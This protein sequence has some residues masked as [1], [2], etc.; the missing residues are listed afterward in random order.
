VCCGAC[1]SVG[2]CC[3]DRDVGECGMFC[4]MLFATTALVA[5]P[6]LSLIF[7]VLRVEDVHTFAWKEV[8]APMWAF[9]IVAEIAMCVGAGFV[10]W[11]KLLRPWMER[12]ESRQD[13]FAP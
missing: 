11:E 7:W 4:G 5:P 9:L 8:I 3:W 1:I 2:K 10:A 13:P 6:I 12:R